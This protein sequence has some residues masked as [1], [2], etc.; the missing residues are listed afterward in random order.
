MMNLN[1]KVPFAP[2]QASTI[3]GSIDLLYFFLLCL[4]F[5][6]TA[7]IYILVV[8]FAVK[9]RRT[10]KNPNGAPIHGNLM[11]EIIWSVIP[12][13][14]VLFIFVWSAKLFY[15]SM[16]P[17]ANAEEVFVVGKQWMWK[18]QH[19]EGKREINTL[20]VPVNRPIRLT[21]TSEDIIHSFY[22]PAFRIK[23]DVVPG[24]YTTAWFQATKTGTY[25]LFCA[26]YCGTKH[27][28]MIGQVIVLTEEEYAAWLADD[29]QSAAAP[30]MK[31]S[32]AE[33]FKASRCNTC[34][35]ETDKGL[36]PTLNGIFGKEVE[37]Q[38]GGKAKVDEAYLRESIINPHAKIVA[39]YSPMMPTY[40]GQLNEEQ[41]LEII[42][43]IKSLADTAA[44]DTKPAGATAAPAASGAVSGEEVFNANRCNTCHQ[45]ADGGLGPS[46][47][48]IYGTQV[49]LQSG[50]TVTVD[51][52][53]LRESLLKPHDKIVTGYGPIMPPYQGLSEEQIQALIDY[54]KSLE[55]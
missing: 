14:I 20:H 26:E 16:T 49:T 9:F 38:G 28:G 44:E 13:G 40:Q 36:G 30:A 17:P 47:H 37:L 23:M 6:F 55:K 31:V 51:E 48:G 43:Y 7:L 35:Q 41:I 53:Y 21:M 12:L 2:E 32:G 25:H 39:G 27:S 19:P 4:T 33:L 8:A 24:R 46:L 54:I 11:L 18:I 10:E 29:I 50:E 34:H 1:I 15:I 45:D 5:F 52:A 22:V 3:A 42:S